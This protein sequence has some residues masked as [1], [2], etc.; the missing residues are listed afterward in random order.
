VECQRH[1]ILLVKAKGALERELG[2]KR[3]V[4]FPL[5]AP[6]GGMQQQREIGGIVARVAQWKECAFGFESTQMCT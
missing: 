4:Y 1:R 2:V 5:Q 3:G 6:M